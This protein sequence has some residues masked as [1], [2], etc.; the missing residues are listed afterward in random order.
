MPKSKKSIHTREHLKASLLIMMQSKP[1][2]TIT[3]NDIV[4]VAELNR[5]SFYRYFDDKYAVIE[6]IEAEILDL[7]EDRIKNHTTKAIDAI[8]CED[9]YH[10]V[11]DTLTYFSKESYRLNII[12]GENGDPSFVHKLSHSIK[13]N[14]KADLSKSKLPE[15]YVALSKEIK[16]SAI[17]SFLSKLDVYTK[18]FTID[19][20]AQLLSLLNKNL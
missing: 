5:S 16:T 10:F 17:I 20:I 19:E 18:Q 14:I 4:Q 13:T 2:N 1:F 15:K 12:L 11:F 6:E 7:F 3:V 8:T 9:T